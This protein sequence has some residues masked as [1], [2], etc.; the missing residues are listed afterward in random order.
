MRLIASLTL[1]IATTYLVD[2]YAPDDFGLIV[3]ASLVALTFLS[4]SARKSVQIAF[5]LAGRRINRVIGGLPV[6]G[7]VALAIWRGLRNVNFLLS[8]AMLVPLVYW[9][10]KSV[11]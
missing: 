5:V 3:V 11:F 10:F 8:I 7:A 6:I 9:A 2:R 4:F 1:V